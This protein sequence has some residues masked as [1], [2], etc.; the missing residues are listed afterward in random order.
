MLTENFF[1]VR[2]SGK[3]DT[4]KR[5]FHDKGIPQKLLQGNEIKIKIKVFRQKQTKTF[6]PN[7]TNVN[8]CERLMGFGGINTKFF[9]E[10]YRQILYI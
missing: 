1:Y 4:C 10:K 8:F 7:V 5:L 6:R 3:G 2:E 9:R